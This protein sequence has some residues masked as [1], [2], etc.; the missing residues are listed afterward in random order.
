[1]T[2]PR[3]TRRARWLY[4]LI[5]AIVGMAYVLLDE[6]ILDETPLPAAGVILHEFLDAIVPVLLGACIGFGIHLF[7]R[8]AHLNTRLSLK[9]DRLRQDVLFHALISQI[10]HE[11][12]NPVHNLSA[13]LEEPQGADSPEKKELVARNLE[14]LRRLKTQYGRLVPAL[15]RLDP[16]EPL[17]FIPWFERLMDE[18]VSFQLRSAGVHWT[19]EFEPA[20][21]FV[22]PVLMEQAMLTLFANAIET[23]EGRPPDERRLSLAVKA[24]GR[25]VEIRMANAGAFPGEALEAQ[26]L[27]PVESRNGMGLGLLLLRTIVE[28]VGGTLKLTNEQGQAVVRLTLPGERT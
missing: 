1:M 18:K 25:F 13:V 8:Q 6:G 17:A 23:L 27:K 7:R 24:Q 3:F 2:L 16:S 9:N 14:R 11:V 19:R 5:G 15:E 26:G 4:P 21:V 28:Q 10:L 12:Q 22:H 20:R